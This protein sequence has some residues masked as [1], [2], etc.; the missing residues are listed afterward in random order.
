MDDEYPYATAEILEVEFQGLYPLLV[1]IIY[2]IVENTSQNQVLCWTGVWALGN[3]ELN[4]L[5]NRDYPRID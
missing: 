2:P 3:F 5:Y 1:L 4:S